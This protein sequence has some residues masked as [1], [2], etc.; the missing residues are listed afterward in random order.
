MTLHDF[1]AKFT[2]RYLWGNFLAMIILGAS[3]VYGA[4]W[5]I[6]YYTNHGVEVSV[7]NL[8]GMQQS[9]A[10]RRLK[11]CGLNCAVSDSGFVRNQPPGTVLEQSLVA[12]TKVKPG[13]IIYITINSGNMPTILLP[14]LAD[15]SSLREA[16]TKLTSIGF[17]L[18]PVEYINGEKDWVYEVKCNGRNVSAGTRIPVDSPITLVVGNGNYSESID[19]DSTE[20]MNGFDPEISNEGLGT[21][22]DDNQS[23]NNE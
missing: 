16:Q 21:Y 12:G 13:R 15:N 1:F 2:G 18:A 19:S 11:A 3:L 20:Y 4:L 8:H 23:L 10:E 5:G 14:D 9:V 17:K 6:D 22:E 7:P